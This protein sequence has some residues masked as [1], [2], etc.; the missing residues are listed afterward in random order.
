MS[1]RP[2]VALLV[3]PPVEV[4]QEREVG[5]E[6]ALD[7]VGVDLGKRAELVIVRVSRITVRYD[8]FSRT[9]A[10]DCG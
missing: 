8:G 6:Q 2:G 4:L 9:L 10:S 3:D 5:R 1:P 7:D